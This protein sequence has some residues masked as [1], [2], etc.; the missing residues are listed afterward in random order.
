VIYRHNRVLAR[1]LEN[2]EGKLF[3]RWNKG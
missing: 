3:I 1:D 2:K